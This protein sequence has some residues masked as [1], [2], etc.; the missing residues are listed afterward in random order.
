MR[1]TLMSMGNLDAY[2]GDRDACKGDLG[3]TM[4][5]YKIILLILFDLCPK[6]TVMLPQANVTCPWVAPA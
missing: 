3:T 1:N 2:T 5:D 6:L 4:V